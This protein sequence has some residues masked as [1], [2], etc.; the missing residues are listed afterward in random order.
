MGL[1]NLSGN[2]LT[3]KDCPNPP[4]EV[5]KMPNLMTLPFV[6]FI[7]SLIPRTSRRH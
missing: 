1:D 2:L 6:W 4:L 5:T 3:Q 7:S